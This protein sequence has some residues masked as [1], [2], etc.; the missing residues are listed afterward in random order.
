MPTTTTVENFETVQII[1]FS[2]IIG[3][4]TFV[5]VVQYNKD[6]KDVKIIEVSPIVAT[7]PIKVDQSTF[8]G[9]IIT[10]TN[11]IEEIVKI[12]KNTQTVAN[13]IIKEY[14]SFKDLPVLEVTLV[15]SD[16]SD[17]F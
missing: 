14:P 1:T 15:Q 11:S 10:T 13:N 16:F 8:D 9:R 5:A 17:V 2:Y 6:T 7:K 12:S 3:D 4:K